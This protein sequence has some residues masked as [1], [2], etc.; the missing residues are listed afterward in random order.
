MPLFLWFP[1]GM[2]IGMS[3][4]PGNN[5][6]HLLGQSGGGAD[7]VQAVAF[8]TKVITMTASATVQPNRGSESCSP[9]MGFRTAFDYGRFSL[10]DD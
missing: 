2:D 7:L 1:R 6:H 3:F 8:T 4:I 9:F 5:T 10:F